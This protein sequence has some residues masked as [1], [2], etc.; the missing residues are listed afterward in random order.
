MGTSVRQ[1]MEDTYLDNRL[2][3]KKGAMPQMPS[4]IIHQD[5]SLWGDNVADMKPV[6]AEG[7]EWK[8][9]TSKNTNVAAVVMQPDEDID[10]EIKTREDFEEFQ[11][12]WTITLDGTGKIF[13]LVTENR[14]MAE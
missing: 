13:A 7:G 3:L 2:L 11:I 5:A 8:Y 6:G 10:V 9:P 12:K 14:I 1:V 4:R